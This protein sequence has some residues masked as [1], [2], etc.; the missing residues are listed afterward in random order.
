MTSILGSEGF[1]LGIGRM[2][3][4]KG[5]NTS[6]RLHMDLNCGLTVTRV[7]RLGERSF[8]LEKPIFASEGL[9]AILRIY[10]S[11]R[12]MRPY[13]RHKKMLG[14][15]GLKFLG[16]IDLIIGLEGTLEAVSSEKFIIA[17]HPGLNPE[18]WPYLENKIVEAIEEAYG[19]EIVLNE[20]VPDG[21]LKM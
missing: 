19:Y 20:T 15:N 6:E 11:D 13:R 3:S 18:A 8:V 2:V 5:S 4:N 12:H 9:P 7:G 17:P 16:L 21:I 1:D 14:E 10:K